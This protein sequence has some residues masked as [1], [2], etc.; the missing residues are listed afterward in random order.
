VP[1]SWETE[2]GAAALKR[3]TA[4]LQIVGKQVN[5]SSFKPAQQLQKQ[6]QQQQSMSIRFAS[7]SASV[8]CSSR[9]PRPEQA[10]VH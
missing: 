8:L 6:H 1:L 9:C 2:G 3:Y 10:A 4:Q 7:P 5:T